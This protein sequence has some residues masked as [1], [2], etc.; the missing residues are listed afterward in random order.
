MRQKTRDEKK[1]ILLFENN[2]AIANLIETILTEAGYKVTR[3]VRPEEFPETYA[4][5]QEIDLVV[6]DLMMGYD[7]LPDEW[8]KDTKNGD[9][10]GLVVMKRMC[11]NPS[12]PV[13][14][15]TGLG[16]DELISEAESVLGE[17][18]KTRTLNRPFTKRELLEAVKGLLR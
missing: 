3:C 17:T 12:V 5:W 11:K 2:E 9:L 6:L 13:V 18:H 7:G 10:T 16:D 1:L 4:E 15:E 8:Q 14:I